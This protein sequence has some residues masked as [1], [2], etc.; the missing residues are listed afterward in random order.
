MD[1]SHPFYDADFRNDEARYFREEEEAA[2]PYVPTAWEQANLDY[3]RSRDVAH[4]KYM[5]EQ[6][7]LTGR[8]PLSVPADLTAWGCLP[9]PG[10]RP[11]G[12]V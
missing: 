7:E 12:D 11:A 4:D 2:L 9:K 3:W 5:R 1:R 6:E 10:P 8:R